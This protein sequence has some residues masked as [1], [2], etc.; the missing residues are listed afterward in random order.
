MIVIPFGFL[1][2]LLG[3]IMLD[4][5]LSVVSLLGVLALSGV[6]I[7]DS[8]ILIVE[9][10]RR[11]KE[12]QEAVKAIIDGACR[13]FRP[14]VL[15]TM[16]TF[17]GLAPMIWEPSNQAKLMIPMA[18]SL[19]FGIVFATLIT[20]VLLPCLYNILDDFKINETKTFC[21]S[22]VFILYFNNLTHFRYLP[23]LNYE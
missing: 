13:R 23:H 11:I 16:T 21:I 1:G 7:N 15:T 22:K 8:L 10:N 3:H 2:A 12:G 14:I 20:L 4:V 17:F 9:I 5:T 19:G 6:V 18:I